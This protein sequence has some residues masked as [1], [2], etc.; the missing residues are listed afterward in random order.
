MSADN[1]D[2]TEKEKPTEM[3]AI[4][5]WTGHEAHGKQ[6][7]A[8]D[9]TNPGDLGGC[10]RKESVRFIVGLKNR[11][12]ADDTP[13]VQVKNKTGGNLEPSEKAT[14]GWCLGLGASRCLD[15]KSVCR[16]G[17]RLRQNGH[18][19]AFLSLGVT[20]AIVAIVAGRVMRCGFNRRVL[21][22]SSL[23]NR[24]GTF[25]WGAGPDNAVVV[26][27]DR[28]DG[29]SGIHGMG[30]VTMRLSTWR[31]RRY[32]DVIGEDKEIGRGYKVDDVPED[33]GHSFL[34]VCKAWGQSRGE[35]GDDKERGYAMRWSHDDSSR[36]ERA[37]A[38][39]M[40]KG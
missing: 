35:K 33:L 31:R 34:C 6:E 18:I 27:D 10:G 23:R 4:K 30:S 15:L 32:V 29:K 5:E 37:T 24:R 25:V 12:G 39:G 14:V 8:L 20:L 16:V 7:K 9:S 28:H 38:I 36:A 11:E 2:A 3:A 40:A 22:G 17:D 19:L 26:A 13:R 1:E 21:G